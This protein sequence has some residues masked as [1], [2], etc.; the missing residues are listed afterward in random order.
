MGRLARHARDS[1]PE[2]SLKLSESGFLRSM[3]LT[4]PVSPF[5]AVRRILAVMFSENSADNFCPSEFCPV[6]PVRLGSVDM[7]PV[8]F[9]DTTPPNT[10]V[11]L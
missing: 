5:V 3:N 2:Y 10:E 4:L 11:R 7:A 6:G 1:V 9:R 8:T